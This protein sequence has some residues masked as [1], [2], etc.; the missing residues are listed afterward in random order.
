[1]VKKRCPNGSRKNK[2]GDCVP[3]GTYIKRK[4]CPNGS[5]KNKTGDCVLKGSIVKRKK[6]PN[7]SRKNKKGDCIK[8]GVSAQTNDEN[9][10]KEKEKEKEPIIPAKENEQEEN[11]LKKAIAALEKAEKEAYANALAE[12]K[13]AAEEEAQKEKEEAQKEKDEKEAFEK[14][15]AAI[16]AQQ[17]AAAE[18]TS[19]IAA[20]KEAAAK[21]AAQEAAA[22][23]AAAIQELTKEQAATK[24]AEVKKA[25]REAAEKA[26]A[27]KKAAEDEAAAQKKVEKTEIDLA[28]DEYARAERQF[29]EIYG[30]YEDA[31]KSGNLR[32][33]LSKAQMNLRIVTVL[34]R[35]MKKLYLLYPWNAK[36]RAI[37]TA[38]H[39]VYMTKLRIHLQLTRATEDLYPIIKQQEAD[40]KKLDVFKTTT[41]KA[42]YR[43]KIQRG[44]VLLHA[45]GAFYVNSEM[46]PSKT[47]KTPVKLFLYRRAQPSLTS[48]GEL[49]GI[50]ALKNYRAFQQ[51]WND[52]TPEKL[53]SISNSL[54]CFNPADDEKGR[55]YIKHC[56]NNINRRT[57]NVGDIIADKKYSFTIGKEGKC[58]KVVCQHDFFDDATTLL[59]INRKNSFFLSDVI[60]AAHSRGMTEIHLIDMSCSVFLQLKNNQYT[61]VDGSAQH[62]EHW[63]KIQMGGK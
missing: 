21:K 22:K 12:Q 54:M 18:K 27:A 5:Q 45:H 51:I 43:E 41:H 16:I 35:A 7:G 48:I 28:S 13:A 17:K 62:M 47:F 8:H 14:K 40:A 4:R 19:A 33:I 15:A 23:Q 9:K 61:K 46:L 39:N 55:N 53:T 56:Y 36:P 1:M 58:V 42:L 49:G 29:N 37:S 24:A 57:Y 63:N 25:I 60:R 3:N 32:L 44:I 26:A 34:E 6:C 50:A 59:Q 52:F 20:E 30:E 38:N 2:Q 11:V 31:V 10:E